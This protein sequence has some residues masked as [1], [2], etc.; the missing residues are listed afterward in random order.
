[1]PK[2]QQNVAQ[3]FIECASVLLGLELFDVNQTRENQLE[4][5]AFEFCLQ[6]VLILPHRRF[7]LTIVEELRQSRPSPRSKANIPA[8]DSINAWGYG[9]VYRYEQLS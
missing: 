9:L 5:L 6:S 3:T 1:L 7:A 4:Q 8:E 2:L